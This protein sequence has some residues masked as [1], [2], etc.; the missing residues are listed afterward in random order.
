[1][2]L[3]LK[4]LGLGVLAVMA[5]SAF[6]AV[7][8]GAR[9]GGHFIAPPH[10]LIVGTES[11][12]HSLHFTPH[13]KN[14]LIGC[15]SATYSGT[16]VNETETAIEVEPSYSGCTTTANGAHVTVTPNG[17]KYRFT[18]EK[19]GT[20]GTADLN[21][22]GSALEIHH[23]NCTITVNDVGTGG[24]EVNQNLSGIHYTTTLESKHALTIDVNVTFNTEYHGGICIFLGTHQL[25]ELNGSVTVKG[26]NTDG[27]QVDITTT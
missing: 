22:P 12:E 21:C 7:N 2:S 1:M 6:A 15:T 19:G 4:I 13:G 11:G 25:G 14:E 20:K 24:V 16:A 9:T 5:T 17:C 27:E 26:T 23:P 8:A 10:T 18:V 3:K